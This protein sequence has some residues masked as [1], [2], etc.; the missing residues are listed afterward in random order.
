MEGKGGPALKE[1]EHP[2]EV[3]PPRHPRLDR[4]ERQKVPGRRRPSVGAPVGRPPRV[5]VLGGP[6]RPGRLGAG[7]GRRAGGGL[8]AAAPGMCPR[9]EPLLKRL[10]WVQLGGPSG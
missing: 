4:H 8:G 3:P 2:A 6:A 5:G 9:A 10:L 7:G 1:E